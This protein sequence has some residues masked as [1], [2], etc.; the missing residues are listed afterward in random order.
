MR[1]LL[2][3][4]DNAIFKTE[5][6]ASILLLLGLVGLVLMQVFNRFVIQEA[7]PW[8]E[9][10]ARFMFTFF[11]F[12]GISAATKVHAHFGVTYLYEKTAGVPKKM[13]DYLIYVSVSTFLV[14][15]FLRSFILIENS[16]L[17]TSATLKIKIGY[18]YLILP[19]FSFATFIHMTNHFVNG[20]GDGQS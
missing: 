14:V 15:V 2:N 13:I 10:L 18:I 17:Q 5:L 3:N 1:K 16:M 19:I 8:S 7:L 12:I 9:E 20:N 11:V 6:C 4:V